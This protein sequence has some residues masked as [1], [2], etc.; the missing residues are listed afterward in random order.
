MFVHNK[1]THFI[2][3][4]NLYTIYVQMPRYLFNYP[5][6]SEGKCVIDVTQ[7][8]ILLKL[9]YM[10]TKYTHLVCQTTQARIYVR[11]MDFLHLK[12]NQTFK[13]RK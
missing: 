7:N 1:H 9:F 12:R 4:K 3:F 5:I 6:F 2:F 11:V 8:W 10:L 13:R